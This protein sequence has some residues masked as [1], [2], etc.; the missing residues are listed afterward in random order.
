MRWE[1]I[2]RNNF[3]LFAACSTT[4][5]GG[6]VGYRLDFKV[7]GPDIAIRLG[8]LSSLLETTSNV[9]AARTSDDCTCNCRMFSLEGKEGV[10]LQTEMHVPYVHI[11]SVFCSALTVEDGQHDSCG[12]AEADSRHR[13][14]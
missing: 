2:N 10:I 3:R 11:F 14:N 5:A 8:K 13:W 12:T 4:T 6:G 9:R 1:I 7:Q